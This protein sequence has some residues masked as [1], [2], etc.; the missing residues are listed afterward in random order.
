MADHA[1]FKD[2]VLCKA[3]DVISGN[4]GYRKYLHQC[5]ENGEEWALTTSANV[6]LVS[7][8]IKELLALVDR[9]R[10]LPNS[11]LGKVCSEL[12]S[13][14][15][16]PVRIIPGWSTC[17][18]ITIIINKNPRI[19]SIR[20]GVITDCQSQNC[21]DVSRGTKHN[22][23]MPVHSKFGYFVLMCFYCCRLEH[24]IRTYTKTW[25]DGQDGE[26]FEISQLTALFQAQHAE[27]I[28]KMHTRF[29]EG[30]THVKASLE[31][32]LCEH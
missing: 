27:L 24:V 21:I 9:V 30:Y 13:S 25:L 26:E 10:R 7:G 3:L 5:S 14:I 12:V 15:H 4:C 19:K 8:M 31:A 16:S 11:K 29:M 23:S 22:Q 32:Y 18:C 1:A 20:A 2:F 6:S 28:C 17:K